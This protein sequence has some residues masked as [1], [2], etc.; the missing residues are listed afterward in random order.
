MNL[1]Q[2]AAN[3]ARLGDPQQLISDMAP[4]CAKSAENHVVANIKRRF[5]R[6]TGRL[7]SS[8]GSVPSGDGF[9]ITVSAE[10][11]AALNWG[12]Q[13]A[14]GREL[15]ARPFVPT[16]EI[17]QGLATTFQKHLNKIVREKLA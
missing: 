7:L 11:S 4:A 5:K 8:V 10:Y 16:Q 6:R 17:P 12:Y 9:R 3:L 15:P 13:Y 14:D 2:L 1:D